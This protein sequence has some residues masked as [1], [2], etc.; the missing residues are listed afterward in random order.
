MTFAIV[1]W[2]ERTGMLGAAAASST[3]P[4]QGWSL[5]GHPAVGIIACGGVVDARLGIDG[6]RHLDGA[7]PRDA[8]LQLLESDPGRDSRQVLIV[9]SRGR[10][11]AYSGRGCLPFFGH[12]E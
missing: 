1:A 6:L 2:D 12:T 7:D 3:S 9:D 8:V 10:T 4:T 5:H 11:A